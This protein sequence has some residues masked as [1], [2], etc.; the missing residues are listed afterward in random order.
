MV[1][2]KKERGCSEG[3][4]GKENQITGG[5]VSRGKNWVGLV[6]A[7]RGAIHF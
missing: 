6:Q 4:R 2:R 5:G 3:T 1:V 7:G